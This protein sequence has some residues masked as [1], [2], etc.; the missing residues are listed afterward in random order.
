R[1]FWIYDADNGVIRSKA[2]IELAK[3]QCFHETAPGA[4]HPLDGVQVLLTG[5]MGQGLRFRL[6][7][8]A[9][10]ALVTTESS[11]D[12]AV[13]LFLAGSLPLSEAPAHG[14]DGDHGEHEGGCG[15][16]SP[17]APGRCSSESP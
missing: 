14:D 11:P 9:I 3:E 13:E 2:L 8:R 4:P 6:A 5:G 17:G 7:D 1:N 10:G 12:R 16:A 15:C